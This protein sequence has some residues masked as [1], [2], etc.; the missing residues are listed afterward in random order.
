MGDCQVGANVS[1]KDNPKEKQEIEI[2]LYFGLFFDGT[3]NNKV[4]SAIAL[5]KRRNDF[6][7][8]YKSQIGKHFPKE[9]NL[10]TL[11]RAQLAEAGIGSVHELDNVYGYSDKIDLSIE[12]NIATDNLSEYQYASSAE[13]YD[14]HSKKGII[15][16]ITK[17]FIDDAR[18][19]KLSRMAGNDADKLIF[20]EQLYSVSTSKGSG[21]TNVAVLNSLYETSKTGKG[22]DKNLYYSTYIEG[23][24]ADDEI[25]VIK[26]VVNMPNSIIGLG[27][28]VNESGVV[29]KCRKAIKRVKDIYESIVVKDDI[30][31]IHCHFDIF[32]FSRGATTARCFTY[33]LNPKK[34]DNYVDLKINKLIC[35]TESLLLDRGTKKLGKKNV[36][37]LGLYDT[38]SSI[39]ILREGTA[40]ILG[41]K[42]LGMSKNEEFSEA[43]S[44]F[45][46]TNV[47]DFGLHS[48]NQADAVLH[49]CALDEYRKN[50][51]LVDIQ[52]SL[53][54][55]G[56]E[57]YIPG[58]HTDIGGGA[59]M[60]L[61]SFKI[62][63]CDEICTRGEIF[64]NLYIRINGTI[65][66]I[67]GLKGITA[68]IASL[69]NL[70]SLPLAYVTIQTLIPNLHK[71]VNGWFSLCTGYESPATYRA[72]KGIPQKELKPV[73][74]PE[75]FSLIE[76][77]NDAVDTTISTISS[78]D[79]ELQKACNSAKS[80]LQSEGGVSYK[81]TSVKELIDE[82]KK[83]IKDLK[84]CKNAI[85]KVINDLH[86]V[87]DNKHSVTDGVKYLIMREVSKWKNQVV[88]LEDSIEIF[89]LVFV[90]EHEK[91]IIPV[92]QRRICMY[93]GN[94][95]DKSVKTDKGKQKL[96][97]PLTA[98]VLKEL[99]WLDDDAKPEG[100]VTWMTG[101]PK[102]ESIEKAEA[103]G[104]SILIERT[105]VAHYFSRENLG[106]CKYASPGYTL[107]GLRA[108]HSWANRFGIFKELPVGSYDIPDDLADFCNKVQS[109]A[110]RRGR[111]I[112]IPPQNSKYNYRYLRQKYLHISINQQIISLA[113]NGLVNGPSCIPVESGLTETERSL[114]L[115]DKWIA[116]EKESFNIDNVITR[117]IYPGVE[118]SPTA[119]GKNYVESPKQHEWYLG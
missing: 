93:T 84:E 34:V 116:S 74:V 47:D 12:K 28:G 53:G 68:S 101:R 81:V 119:G 5:N 71:A 14:A 4:Q 70:A 94:P 108:M 98:E 64:H 13:K 86:E 72:K 2:N 82:G 24:G 44:M 69:S 59:S 88:L 46:D 56:C 76:D 99:G 10:N 66:L 52:N 75:G 38:V 103:E 112:C 1:V 89:N 58:C 51:A 25:S 30:T 26:Q 9:K 110:K 7:K 19:E 3:N 109:A 36:R 37:T 43:N 33:I 95:Y 17:F 40:Y 29:E 115:A 15:G 22:D 8:K 42:L 67:K 20:N 113:D 91:F 11:T 73:E 50:F 85:L 57:I 21:Y 65:E 107:I 55:N 16:K 117:R 80:I 18:R 114:L 49:I 61:D 87:A 118:K 111:Q 92:E 105:K 62:I 63:N 45:H 48:T 31:K 35:G 77:F 54:S 106:I 60:G 90:I 78:S 32:G 27:F 39:G 96:I 83:I 100:N 104:K 97:K 102:G 79:A 41:D 6:F 23:S